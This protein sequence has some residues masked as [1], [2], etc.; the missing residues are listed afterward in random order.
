LCKNTSTNIQNKCKKIF[1]HTQR[2]TKKKNKHK[3]YFN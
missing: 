2:K 1:N 3:T